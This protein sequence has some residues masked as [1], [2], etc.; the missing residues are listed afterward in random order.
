MKANKR[1][2][3]IIILGAVLIILL[4]IIPFG[5]SAMIYEDNFGNRYEKYEPMA[6]SIDEFEELNSNRYTFASDEGQILVG[7]GYYRER[8]NT[9]TRFN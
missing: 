5:V 1:K 6:R 9:S 7:Y 4:F 8:E 2:I 3:I